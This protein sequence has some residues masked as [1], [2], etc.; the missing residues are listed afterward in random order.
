MTQQVKKEDWKDFFDT[1]SHERLD[2]ETRIQV[3]AIETGA[4]VLS[5]G[6]PFVGATFEE[7]S[8]E[9]ELIVGTG[10]LSHQTHTIS[11]PQKVAYEVAVDGAG[12]LDIEDAGG[13]QTLIN[14]KQALPAIIT[15]SETE[16]LSKVSKI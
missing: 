13:T 14:F 12:S 2:W 15:Y 7:K 6:L 1:L 5:S 8:V 16:E 10:S 9:I 11:R 3:L 4:Q